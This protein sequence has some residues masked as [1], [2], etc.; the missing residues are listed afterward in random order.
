MYTQKRLREN[1]NKDNHNNNNINR[2]RYIYYMLYK[3]DPK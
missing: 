2:N 3:N 1:I